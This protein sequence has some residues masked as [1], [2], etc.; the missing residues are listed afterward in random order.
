MWLFLSLTHHVTMV[1]TRWTLK[2]P[3]IRVLTKEKLSPP[4]PSLR[5]QKKKNLRDEDIFELCLHSFRSPPPEAPLPPLSCN[6]QRERHGLGGGI[7]GCGERGGVRRDHLISIGLI[8]F[9]FSTE[10]S[11]FFSG[12][13]HSQGFLVFSV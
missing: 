10:K 4:T 5:E 3:A 11:L 6:N 9:V 7:S 8:D 13:K 12:R 1:T 2:F